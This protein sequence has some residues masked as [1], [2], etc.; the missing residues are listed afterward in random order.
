MAAAG[1]S[2]LIVTG[3]TAVLVIG[4]QLAFAIPLLLVGAPRDTPCSF[5]LG[6]WA[7]AFGSLTIASIPFMALGLFCFIGCG[8]QLRSLPGALSAIFLALYSLAAF[9]LLIWGSALAF[10]DGRFSAWQNSSEEEF[11]AAVCDAK[12]YKTSAI[13][14]I[15][16]WASSACSCCCSGVRRAG[17]K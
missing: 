17:K 4:A 1:I 11:S 10:S 8:A 9:G 14:I 13:I 12:L 2:T 6:S 3:C 16:L 7:T 5:P 15:F